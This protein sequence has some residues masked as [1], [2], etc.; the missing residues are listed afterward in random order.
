MQTRP[1]DHLP[2]TISAVYMYC[3]ALFMAFLANNFDGF[4]SQIVKATMKLGR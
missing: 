2:L 1:I 4:V 3:I